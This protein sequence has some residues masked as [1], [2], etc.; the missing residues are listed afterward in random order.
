MDNNKT[1]ETLAKM[2]A[3]MTAVSTADKERRPLTPAEQKLLPSA[4]K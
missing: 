1:A 4:T 3:L 2:L